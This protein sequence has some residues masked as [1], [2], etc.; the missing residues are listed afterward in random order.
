MLEHGGVGR[1]GP[2]LAAHIL[3]SVAGSVPTSR[4]SQACVWIPGPRVHTPSHFS[5]LTV[6]A[7]HTVG[8]SGPGRWT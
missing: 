2:W 7:V 8:Q 3:L 4:G 5:V 1:T 6:L